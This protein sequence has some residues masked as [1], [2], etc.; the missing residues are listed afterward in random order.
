[1]AEKFYIFRLEE[2]INWYASEMQP[3]G[4]TN[5]E[6]TKENIVL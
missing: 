4:V 3:F 1:M 2:C 5:I 6:Q